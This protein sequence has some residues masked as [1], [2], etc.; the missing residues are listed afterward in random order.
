M[1]PPP[2]PSVETF[3]DVRDRY[4]AFMEE[5]LYPNEDALFR[6]DDA[7]DELMTQLRARAKAEGLWAPHLPP[8][9]GGTGRASS[10]TRT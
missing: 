9:A 8:E 7:A 6:E 4:R 2:H 5:H 10:S 1:T 3:A